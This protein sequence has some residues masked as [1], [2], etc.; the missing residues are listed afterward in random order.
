MTSANFGNKKGHRLQHYMSNSLAMKHKALL[1]SAVALAIFMADFHVCVAEPQASLANFITR[2]GDQL[3][4]GEKPYRFIGANMPGLVV[5]Y[6]FYL[7]IPERMV[8][9]TP[10]ELEDAM[11]TARQ[12]NLSCLRTWNLPIRKPTEKPASWH[13]VLGPGEFNEA[14]FVN[15]DH[16]L[17]LAN[18]YGI[19]IMLDLTAD[20][21]DYLGG[22][23]EYAAHRGKPR[24]AFFTDPQVKADFKATIKHVLTRVNTVSGVPYKNDKAILA[25]QFGNEM[26]RTY[27]QRGF[28]EADQTA[29]QAEMAAY[30]KKLDPNHLIAYG[31]RFFPENPD[32][33][34]DIIVYHYYGNCENW[35][36]LCD[37]HRAQTKGK[38]PFVIGEWGLTS[39]VDAIRRMHDAAIANGTA[40]AMLWSMYFHHRNGG[41]WW[42]AIITTG[43]GTFAFH[44]PGFAEGASVNEREIL[45]LLREKSYEIQGQPIPKQTVPEAAEL[46]PFDRTAM[47]SWRGAA[48][49][50]AYDIQRAAT[51]EG[52]WTV[53]A[54]NVSDSDVSYRP[55]FV[56]E[57]ARPGETWFY[58]VV[59]RNVAGHG[60]ASNVVG[61]VQ[62]ERA[63]VVDEM[64][65]FSQVASRTEG[66]THDNTNNKYFA[67]YLHR[68]HGNEDD[69]VSYTT[70]GNIRAVKMWG[71]IPKQNTP[72]TLRLSVSADGKTFRKLNCAEN[73]RSFAA[74]GGKSPYV[75]V[76]FTNGDVD[77]G[78]YHLKVDF[79][80]SAWIDRI[81]V[82]CE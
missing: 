48:G 46:L 75:E 68:F 65:D 53:L 82:E 39:D 13:Y 72:D 44:W 56:D 9:P 23:A 21:G 64:H 14:A 30:M 25:W 10:W 78:V 63:L 66:V 74:N 51:A 27:R 31:K 7:N 11:K 52:P 57:S 33:N 50:A 1:V 35:A 17:A 22:V 41:F 40:G 16:M 8:L 45:E 61:P 2:R 29:W 28:N 34:V 58:R 20:C 55:L 60:P 67:D 32:P 4:D 70:P 19:R 42:H 3:F 62:I 38:R 24:A 12:M 76:M 59:A 5:P 18:R 37:Q 54:E 26:D 43:H 15:L 77:G 73:M 47:F 49:A 69:S 80:G 36:K 6:D 79:N 71:W 81:E